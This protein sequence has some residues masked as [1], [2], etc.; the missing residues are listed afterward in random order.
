VL[1]VQQAVA[2]QRARVRRPLPR[3]H[4]ADASS[5]AH[6]P[7][8]CTSECS[9]ARS[10]AGVRAGRVLVRAVVRGLEGPD[11]DA[12]RIKTEAARAS[13][14]LVALDRVAKTRAHRSAG[15]PCRGG[16]LG[17]TELLALRRAPFRRP[18]HLNDRAREVD[19]VS[20]RGRDHAPSRAV[21]LAGATRS[22][23]RGAALRAE[24]P[25]DAG[26]LGCTG[27]TG[28]D[29]PLPRDGGVPSSSHRLSCFAARAP[30]T[31]PRASA[32]CRRPRA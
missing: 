21:E 32:P 4:P 9:Q 3:T 18:S 1:L 25:R 31:H 7:R 6:G 15:A 22:A 29:T 14:E 2:S 17:V 19:G 13:P 10:V 16:G 12:R 24:G 5:G 23:L 27:A 11:R 26:E 20:A 28:S 8:L 30:G